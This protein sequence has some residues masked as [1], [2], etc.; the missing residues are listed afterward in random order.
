MQ[1]DIIQ[2]PEPPISRFLFADTRLGIMWLVLRVY[3]GWVWLSAG[4]GKFQNEAWIGDHAGTA[5]MGFFNRAL[6]K[7]SG[8]H[9]DVS[10]WYAAFL[11]SVAIPHSVLFSH[12]ITFGEIAVGLGLILGAFTGISAFFGAFMNLNFL[13][14]GSVSINPVLLLCQLFLILAWRNAGWIGLDRFI[15]PYLGTPWKP[16]TLFDENKER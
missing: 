5:I 7:T 10:G 12:L 11:N 8:E 3:V 4:W 15:L 13:F 9:P 6:Q 1:K 2:I 16:G 14:A